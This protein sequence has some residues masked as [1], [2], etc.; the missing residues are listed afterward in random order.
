MKVPL[1]KVL[2]Q[3]HTFWRKQTPNTAAMKNQTSLYPSCQQH[4][5][6]DQGFASSPLAAFF[7]QLLEQTLVSEATI[8]QDNACAPG[9]SEPRKTHASKAL[10]RQRANSR[11][12][13]QCS[14]LLSSS[15]FDDDSTEL[16]AEDLRWGARPSMDTSDHSNDSAR[17][18]NKPRLPKRRHSPIFERPLLEV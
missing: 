15:A 9:C 11:T 10:R 3:H 13:S 4:E 12:L 14:A 6:A 2:S 17:S 16:L 5:A 1:S 8:V 7:T 18:A